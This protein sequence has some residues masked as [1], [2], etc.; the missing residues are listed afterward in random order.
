LLQKFFQVQ[1]GMF[2][3]KNALTSLISFSS[4]K[5]LIPLSER[6][7]DIFPG[8]LAVLSSV[9]V[10]TTTFYLTDSE[11]VFFIQSSIFAKELICI[12]IRVRA[13]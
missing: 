2:V 3:S 5:L 8:T 9:E 11:D 6:I 12:I 4:T 1:V 10:E 13:L 7:R